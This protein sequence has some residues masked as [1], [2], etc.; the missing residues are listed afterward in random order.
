MEITTT[1]KLSFTNAPN[2]SIE[3][4]KLKSMTFRLHSI[5]TNSS[6]HQAK[7][8]KNVNAKHEYENESA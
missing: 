7:K 6:K 3:N 1:T 8:K 5:L 4:E 2:Q